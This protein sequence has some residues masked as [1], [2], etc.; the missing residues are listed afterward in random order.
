MQDPE[1]VSG[2]LIDVAQHL[3]NLRFKV[4]KKMQE[5]VQYSEYKVL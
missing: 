5:M 1:P 3:G 2:A 4:W